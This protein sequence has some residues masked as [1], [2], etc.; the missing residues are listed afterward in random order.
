IGEYNWNS[1]F[2][3][4]NWTYD[5]DELWFGIQSVFKDISSIFR[6]KYN[7]SLT[8][9]GGIGISAMMHGYLAIGKNGKLLVPFRTW[10]NTYTKHA[11]KILSEEFKFNV[12]HRWSISHL[13]H[14][15]LNNEDHIRDI[16]FITT[17]AGYVHWKLTDCNILGAGDASGLFPLNE[18]G[19]NYNQFMLQNFL[20][21]ITLYDI[22]YKITNIIPK[23]KLAGD[24]A[25]K[26]TKDGAKLLD[27]S[28]ILSPGIEFCPP[29]GDAGTGMVATNTLTPNTGNISAGTS[30]FS[31]IVLNKSLRGYYEEVDIVHTPNGKPVAMIHCNNFT[32]DLNEWVKLFHEFGRMLSVELNIEDTFKILFNKSQESDSD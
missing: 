9:I 2:K 21:L 11:A 29:E 24:T 17:L 32:K 6:K 30:I 23:V 5:I 13:Y 25:G 22:Q 1:Y 15:I 27:P 14:A 31:M 26:L 8:N 7:S 10:Q 28:G 3:D 18:E 4:N 16:R 19:S 12:P 20:N